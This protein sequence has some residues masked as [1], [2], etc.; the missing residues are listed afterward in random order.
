M[1]KVVAPVSDPA[2]SLT[3][4]SAPVYTSF[5]TGHH[6]QHFPTIILIIRTWWGSNS[7]SAPSLSQSPTAFSMQKIILSSKMTV[8][9]GPKMFICC[10]PKMPTEAL[11]CQ[12]NN[13][14]SRCVCC[15]RDIFST[16]QN[17]YA[18]S[19]SLFRIHCIDEFRKTIPCTSE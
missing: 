19:G 5:S 9:V 10:S 11:R 15:S 6:Q 17:Y 13:S 18:Y 1:D 2:V 7:V 4:A 14:H 16:N 3:S 12:R 8:L